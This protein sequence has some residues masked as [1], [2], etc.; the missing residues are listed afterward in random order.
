MTGVTL[1]ETVTVFESPLRLPAA[2]ESVGVV[3]LVREPGAANSFRP[4]TGA[5]VSTVHV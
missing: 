2:P 3:S 1:I 4:T 5:T